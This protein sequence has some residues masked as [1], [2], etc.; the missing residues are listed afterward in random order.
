MREKF[1]DYV[2][3]LETYIM[4]RIKERVAKLAPELKAKGRSPISLSMGAPTAAPPKKVVDALK[5]ALDE[6]GAHLYSTPKGEKFFRE[7][8]AKRMK[9]RFNV[10]LNPDEEIFSLIGSKEGIA[11]FIRLLINPTTVE[12]DKDIILVPDPGYASYKEMVK[13]S[14]GI[15][16]SVPLKPENNYMPNMEEVLD[17]FVKD[18]F[19]PKKIKALLINYPNNPLGATA[20]IEYFKSVVEFC[21]KHDILL[22]SDAAYTDMYFKDEL[23]PPSIL[24]V[25]GAKDIA[26]EFFSMSK[27][28]AMTGW[29]LGWICG[30]AEAVKFFGKLKST[31]DSGIF[32]ALQKASAEILL[33]E[34]G[35]EYIE[36][37]NK[38]FK[39]NQ[40]I[41]VKGL[42]EELG[43]CDFNVPDATFYL[44]VPIPP[45]YK[46]AV[47]FTDDLLT[48]SGIVA[49][50]GDAFGDYG[51]GYIRVSIVCPEEQIR[52]V[53]KRMKT[54]GFTFQ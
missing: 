46:T 40:E 32:K 17:Q 36:K 12:K 3:S 43:W 27:P 47:E 41:F 2:Q 52:E 28:Y 34:E 39:R 29:R 10:E 16:Y 8:I 50:P 18:G 49:V 24:E 23:K 9:K 21:K 45:R 25:E 1:N 51:E 15:S 6:D 22:V 20:T 7:A 44:W 53:I 5:S 48:K 4:F 33:S 19:N 14:G 26:V 11:N 13:V 42:K 37:S 35:D 31:I 30:N 54:D 38:V